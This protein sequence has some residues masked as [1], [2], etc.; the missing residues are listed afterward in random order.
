MD[1]LFGDDGVILDPLNDNAGILRAK[2][3]EGL[4]QEIAAFEQ[5][6]PQLFLSVY[7]GALP[8]L[9][10]LRLF[11]FWLLNRATVSCV[12]VTRPNENGVL[13]ILDVTSRSAAI[14]LGYMVE[15][16]VDERDISAVLRLGRPAFTRGQK[17]RALELVVAGLARVLTERAKQAQR[18]PEDFQT[19]VA[20]TPAT[21]P[22][23]R[24]RST[25]RSVKGGTQVTALTPTFTEDLDA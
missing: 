24:V 13:L 5:R 17:G 4:L 8:T 6:F 12:D 7:V 3:R 9:A 19:R 2:E 18:R 21:G 22:I 25:A 20:V 1:A 14:T 15:R 16:F 23:G 10:S 11:G